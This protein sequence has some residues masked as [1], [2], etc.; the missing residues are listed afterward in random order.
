M[1]RRTILNI[2]K[3][4]SLT[5]TIGNHQQITYFPLQENEHRNQILFKTVVPARCNQTENAK[6]EVEKL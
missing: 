2:N 6:R 1:C 3:E 4:V 5:V